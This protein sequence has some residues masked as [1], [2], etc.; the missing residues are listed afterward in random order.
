ML[1]QVENYH[2]K[3]YGKNYLLFI[4][5]SVEIAMTNYHHDIIASVNEINRFIN[6]KNP[7][8]KRLQTAPGD[9]NSSKIS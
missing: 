5:Q 1:T 6:Q 2:Q 7:H 8:V 4:S 3:I 9:L